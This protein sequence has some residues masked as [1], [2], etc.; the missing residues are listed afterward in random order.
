MHYCDSDLTLRAI[1]TL[2]SE[3]LQFAWSG[4]FSKVWSRITTICGISIGKT[5][6]AS[7]FEVQSLRG[8]G[9]NDAKETET[10]PRF[11]VILKTNPLG[12]EP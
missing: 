7:L 10:K 12:F 9:M 6:N 11:P 2:Q 1:S 8:S 3:D 4:R 5:F